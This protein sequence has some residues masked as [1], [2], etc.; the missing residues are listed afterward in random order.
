M[1]TGPNGQN[2]NRVA[3]AVM[4]LVFGLTGGVI[5]A[6]AMG[7]LPIDPTRLEAP[8]WVIACAGAMFIAGGL[9]PLAAALRFPGW[10]TRL[11]GLCAAAGLAAVFN[12]VAFFPGERHFSGGTSILGL[13]LG[14]DAG[15]ELIGRVLFGLC[16]L[17]LDGIVLVALWRLVRG[18][19]RRYNG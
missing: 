16:A 19:G 13:R 18:L 9:A 7:W 17:L 4:A 15:G 1:E 2:L 11:A 5:L 12:W 8:R 10:A 3:A 14:S 6:L